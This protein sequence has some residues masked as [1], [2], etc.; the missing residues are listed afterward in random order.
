[1]CL[2]SPKTPDPPPPPQPAKPPDVDMAKLRQRNRQG[3][4]VGGSLL[5]G[6][7]GLSGPVSTGRATLLGG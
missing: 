6:P 1:M 4:M 2:K 3:G 7:S 5:T